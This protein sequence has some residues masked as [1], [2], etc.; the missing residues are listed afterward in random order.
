MS[1][2][3][4]AGSVG[5]LGKTRREVDGLPGWPETKRAE[6]NDLSFAS[7]SIA[8]RWEAIVEDDLDPQP[9]IQGARDCFRACWG[10]GFD[11]HQGFDFGLPGIVVRM[12]NVQTG[13]KFQG[14]MC[15]GSRLEAQCATMAPFGFPAD[16]TS[17]KSF[18][19]NS[20]HP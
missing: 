6:L 16:R 11:P 2:A 4:C 18:S 5:F 8:F 14:L 13:D 15:T 20:H 9:H 7:L 12:T 3:D 17:K 1:L 10:F 19:D